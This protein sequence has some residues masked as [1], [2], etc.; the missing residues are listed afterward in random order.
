MQELSNP[1]DEESNDETVD[2][3]QLLL[4]YSICYCS[5]AVFLSV[6]ICVW[7]IVHTL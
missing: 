2:D 7:P 1:Q 6:L 3:H 4:D 5:H